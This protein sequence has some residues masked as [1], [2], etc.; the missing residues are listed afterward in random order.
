MKLKSTQ[1]WL[2]YGLMKI[3]LILGHSKVHNFFWLNFL[4]HFFCTYVLFV[5]TNHILCPYNISQRKLHTQ[6]CMYIKAQIVNQSIFF[7]FKSPLLYILCTYVVIIFYRCFFFQVD[8]LY[9]AT[10]LENDCFYSMLRACKYMP[11][12]KK[13]DCDAKSEP[14]YLATTRKLEQHESCWMVG[15]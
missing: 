8:N 2:W 10:N 4:K 15:W 1:K 9:L 6:K 12:C 14:P 3:W 7:N 5:L 11:L 13:L